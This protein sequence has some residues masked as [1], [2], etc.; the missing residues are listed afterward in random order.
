LAIGHL[1]D[2]VS[3]KRL[4]LSV[5][6]VQAL[7]L[8]GSLAVSGWAFYLL[9]FL[10]MAAIFG[11]I[12]FTDAM[13]VRYVDDSMR[14]R[15]SGMRLAVALGASSLAVWLI[16]PLVRAAGFTALLAVM[17]GVSLLTLLVVSQ[18]PATP[19]PERPGPAPL[20]AQERG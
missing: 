20:P 5:V 15:V 18:L 16:G 4:Y 2:R 8:A 19:A 7:V 14:S 12:P 1:I 9:Q 11:A 10:F 17:V 13:I 3:L 6:A